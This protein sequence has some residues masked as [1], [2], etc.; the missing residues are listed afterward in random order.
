MNAFSLSLSQI[1][2]IYIATTI[3]LIGLSVFTYNQV[4][5]LNE[6]AEELHHSAQIS[7]ELEKV[8]ESIKDAETGHRGFLLTHDSTFLKPFYKGIKQYPL[9]IEK[10]KQLV[11]K[12]RLQRK[13][14]AQAT[15][16]CERRV[17]HLFSLLKISTSRAPS[18]AE[19]Q[20][21]NFI[22]DSLRFRVNNMNAIENE[23]AAIYNEKYKQV[24]S[25]TPIFIIILFIGSLLVLLTS[26]FRLNKAMVAS[27]KSSKALKE[28]VMEAS[29][30][31]CMLRG[32]KHY[33]ELANKKFLEFVNDRDICY[34]YFKEE[35]PEFSDVFD[36]LDKVYSTGI[37]IE[38][39]G[40]T[41][42]VGKP[43]EN[44]DY[45]IFNFTYK[46]THN[47]EHKIDGVV[48]NAIDVTVETNTLK[49]I[50]RSHA[51]YKELINKLPV[52]VYTCDAEGNIQLFNEA[53]ELL[54]G[55]TPETGKDKWCGS[56][57]LFSKDGNPL[58]LI[59]SP[60]A[61]TLKD[62][63]FVK[64]ELILEQPD[65]SKRFIIPSPQPVYDCDKKITG[66]I[67]TLVD[68]TEQV[69]A[70][71]EIETKEELLRIAI[72]GGELGTF[73]Y[74]PTTNELIW[75][76]K[77]KEIFG[78]QHT[79]QSNYETYLRALHP[80][81]RENFKTMLDNIHQPDAAAMHEIEYRIF[82]LKEGKLKW[83]R[84]SGKVTLDNEKNV[85]R[86]T[87][88]IQEITDQKLTK[89]IIE[90][91]ERR[92]RNLAETLPQ[93]I[94]VTDERGMSEFT[95]AR[96]EEYTGIKPGGIKEWEAIV[97]PD[98]LEAINKTWAHCLT[99]GEVYKFNVR[100]RSKTGQYAWH[101][102]I[103]EPVRDENDTIVN[104]VGAFTEIHDEKLFTLKLESQ[105]KERTTEL[106]EQN[107]RLEKANNEL[108]LFAH[109]SSHDLQ[110]PLRKV[111]MSISRIADK[112]F[113]SLSEKGK[114]HFARVQEATLTM[115]T[116]IEDLQIYSRTN[117][118][119]GV[120][121]TADLNLILAE[122]LEGLKDRIDEK[123]AI[124]ESGDLC[125]VDI[126]AFE[127]RQLMHNMIGNALKFSKP[128]VRPHIKI[129]SISS[130]GHKLNNPNL[131]PDEMYCYISISDNGIGFE[132]QYNEKIFEVFQRLH[133]KE[134]YR[135]TGIGLAIAK[136]VV[137]NHGG[138][139]TAKGEPGIGAT[140]EIYIPTNKVN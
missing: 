101:R 31:V 9:H 68:I 123:Q 27:N 62:G 29:A 124:I 80:D 78:S 76:E 83:L 59:D 129:N 134:E 131:K 42:N 121:E 122:V 51:R 46:A 95:S 52:A 39:H 82:S 94:W 120:F 23:V 49:E 79:T 107:S 102:V 21:G 22:M 50:E 44:P 89:Q 37:T 57:K 60:M 32:P 85:T 75:S 72:E 73:D 12:S 96:W 30:S 33:I 8:L 71:R 66:S 17:N 64:M 91:S 69:E 138:I 113:S 16:L 25:I 53:A 103:G 98:D 136:K 130:Y 43:G 15:A 24:S 40:V 114:I 93:L 74:Y 109:I 112:D 110:E 36:L 133:G 7:V 56:Q 128:N 139:I 47:N 115:Q 97:H 4:N 119:E 63:K 58:A 105:V 106:L 104:W 1:R 127:F 3:F 100:L 26:Y 117:N 19:L 41:I 14:L 140:F 81:D 125:E 70:R 77:T 2:I 132:S 88:V 84:S 38:K 87:G 35:L 86:F 48:I 6:A 34:K 13:N 10:V 11:S 90:E 67:N 45:R 108:E 18:I 92:F 65:G 118:K 135:G 61:M 28:I 116:L 111:Q 126:L 99:T 20:M 55:R 5:S 54:W 137:E